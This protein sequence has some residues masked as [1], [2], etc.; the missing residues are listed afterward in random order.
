MKNEQKTTY[1]KYNDKSCW[2]LIDAENQTLGRLS[3]QIATILQGKNK[4]NYTSFLNT[5]DFVVVVNVDKM[6]VTGNKMTQK[7]YYHHTG[8]PGGLKEE[9]LKSLFS[10]KPEQ[11]LLNA[12]KGMLPKN[13]L[14]S[15]SI[16]RLKIYSGALHP[17]KA[18]FSTKTHS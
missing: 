17:H 3:T 13:K 16:N 14:R 15:P 18:Q 7:I 6:Q 5:G 11:V 4:V 10:R 9:P 2:I 12:V 8:Y 1:A